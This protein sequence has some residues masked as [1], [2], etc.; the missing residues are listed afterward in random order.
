MHKSFE[1][2]KLIFP[3]FDTVKMQ[4]ALQIEKAMKVTFDTYEDTVNY[5]EELK[6]EICTIQMTQTPTG[7]EHF[8]TPSV[9]AA[10]TTEGQKPPGRLRK[11]RYTSLLLAHRFAYDAEV[12]PTS[13]IDYEDVA[14]NIKQVAADPSEGMYRGP[15]VGQMRNAEWVRGSPMTALKRGE[16]I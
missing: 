11:D 12:A 14:G 15:G 2:K 3:A 7:K 5:I 4:A 8:D 16:R 9:V 10:G 6:N 13:N 1:T